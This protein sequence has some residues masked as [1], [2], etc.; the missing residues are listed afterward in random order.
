MADENLITSVEPA[1]PFTM[2]YK[3]AKVSDIVLSVVKEKH[4][5]AL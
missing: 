5:I 2:A 1:T 3:M 4:F